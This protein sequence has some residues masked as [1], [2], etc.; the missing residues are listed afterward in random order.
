MT[1]R[2]ILNRLNRIFAG[3]LVLA[4]IAG[5]F[6]VPLDASL[7]IHWGISGEPDNFAPAPIA[8]LIPL[9]MAS[10]VIGLLLVLRRSRLKKDM[11]A[12]RYLIDVSSSFILA[13]AI[14]L[15]GI[16]IAIGLG[17]SVD[18]PRIIAFIVGAMLVGLGNYLPKTQPNWI[19]GIRVPWTL[20]DPA[21]WTV[22]HRWGG[23]LM[24]AGGLVAVLAA[25]FNPPA[26]VL[27]VVILAAALLPPIAAIAISYAMSQRR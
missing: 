3:L 25:I 14:V 11:E 13:L 4:T 24:M 8:L 6:L 27:F 22:T 20:E 9:V 1:E 19:A 15:V 12:G 21:N 16:T 10:A 18:V 2:P 23:W 5:F 7:P 26:P 17:V